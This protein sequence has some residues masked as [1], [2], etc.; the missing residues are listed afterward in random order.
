MAG[1][2]TL[3]WPGLEAARGKEEL[4]V[5]LQEKRAAWLYSLNASAPEN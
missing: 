1:R 5:C 3:S 4:E 2:K